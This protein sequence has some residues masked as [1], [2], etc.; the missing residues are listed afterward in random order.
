MEL[1]GVGHS[2]PLDKGLQVS[3]L[4]LPSQ[5]TNSFHFSCAALSQITNAHII[6]EKYRQIQSSVTTVKGAISSFLK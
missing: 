2:E 1:S 6:M 3:G 5:V 4:H